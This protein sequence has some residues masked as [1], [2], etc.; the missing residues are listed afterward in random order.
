MLMCP[1]VICAIQHLCGSELDSEEEALP[2]FSYCFP[3]S[4]AGQESYREIVFVLSML[5]SGVS[6][7][8]SPAMLQMLPM[9]KKE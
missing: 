6:D 5:K 2:I 7:V 9:S 4:E 1:L 8:F 3:G